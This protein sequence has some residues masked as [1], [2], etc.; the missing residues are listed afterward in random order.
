MHI[1][2]KLFFANDTSKFV[3]PIF[4]QPIFVQTH[5][6]PTHIFPTHISPKIQDHPTQNL[7]LPLRVLH[8]LHKSHAIVTFTYLSSYKDKFINNKRL[9]Q[10][11][12]VA[13]YFFPKKWACS[14]KKPSIFRWA[15]G[16]PQTKTL[17]RG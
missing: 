1:N 14:Q 5:I 11:G 12:P 13:D 3:K 17:V 10:K 4:V 2:S 8:A 6:C 7:I 9:F 15:C 16:I